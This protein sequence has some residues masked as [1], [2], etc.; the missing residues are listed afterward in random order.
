MKTLI[1]TLFIGLSAT[2]QTFN[3]TP[4]GLLGQSGK[5]YSVI[6]MPG[7]SA[8]DLYN[9]ALVYLNGIYANPDKVLSTVP[10]H[11]ISINGF[12]ANAVRRN[13]MHAFD[14]NYTIVVEFKDEKIKLLPAS[15]RMTNY[16]TQPQTLHLV[17]GT[18]LTGANLG[19][20]GKSGKLKS[21]RAKTD[22]EG[23]FNAFFA[24]FVQALSGEN[25]W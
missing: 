14:L 19:I 20:F 13:S 2:A 9:R 18:D 7:Q 4:Y 3:L 25:K 17:W 15:Y 23:F 6:D 24:N 8:E 10:H 21:E 11:S 16:S 1:I 5:E 12:A 22:L